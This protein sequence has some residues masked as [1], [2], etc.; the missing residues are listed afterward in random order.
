MT[1]AIEAENRFWGKAR[2]VSGLFAGHVLRPGVLLFVVATDATTPRWA[3]TL[4]AFGLLYFVSPIDLIPDPLPFG[5]VDD[6][7][8]LLTILA[9]L[10]GLVREDHV[11]RTDALLGR[12][13]PAKGRGRSK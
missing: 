11:A 3:R 5:Y 9:N 13:S 8:V 6:I 2:R 1:P 4:I 10:G 12:R 7:I